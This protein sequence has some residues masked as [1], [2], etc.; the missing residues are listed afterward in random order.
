MLVVCGARA[1]FIFASAV[2]CVRVRVRVCVCVCVCVCRASGKGVWCGGGDPAHNA[3]EPA[4]RTQ[5]L[6]QITGTTLPRTG[7]SSIL[8]LV[9]AVRQRIQDTL[10]LTAI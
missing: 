10:P 9:E 1:V 3:A 4:L 8:A 2:R 7:A 6:Q 5:T